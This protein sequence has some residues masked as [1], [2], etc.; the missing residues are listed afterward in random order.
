MQ[1]NIKATGIIITPAVSDYLDEKLSALKK[2][3]DVN[4]D[5]VKI[6]VEIGKTTK[7]HQSGDDLFR[8]EINI[9]IGGD[10]L[11]AEAEMSDLFPAIDI[12]KDKILDKLR[13]RKEKCITKRRA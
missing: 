7:H 10:Y 8:A 3:I 2:L 6:Q 4:D 13:E 1:T 11:R 9:E 12:M 5:T